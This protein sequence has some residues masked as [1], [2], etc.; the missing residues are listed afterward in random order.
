MHSDFSIKGAFFIY[1]K[2]I[3]FYTSGLN[4][5]W[6]FWSTLYIFNFIQY[7]LYYY[8]SLLFDYHTFLIPLSIITISILVPYSNSTHSS[9]ILNFYSSYLIL[10]LTHSSILYSTLRVFTYSH[11]IIHTLILLSSIIITS[12]LYC[13]FLSLTTIPYY[14][15][16]ILVYISL[17]LA[18]SH[19]ACSA[20]ITSPI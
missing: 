10:H 3:V 16:Q 12:I 20:R 19:F 15:S 8:I 6:V 9:Y 4:Y 1:V 18:L 17:H 13:L 7:N 2:I 5:W 11:C 14:L